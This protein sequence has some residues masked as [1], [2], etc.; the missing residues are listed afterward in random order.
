[1]IYSISAYHRQNMHYLIDRVTNGSVSGD[2]VHIINMNPYRKVDVRVINNYQITSTLLV[3]AGGVTCSHNG[4]ILL[5]IHQCACH[6]RGKTIHY[7]GLI[8]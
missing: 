5:I 3:T 2:D 4:E 6:G 1:M 8:E 7:S